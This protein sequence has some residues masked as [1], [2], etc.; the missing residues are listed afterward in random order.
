[1]IFFLC[2]HKAIIHQ[3]LP[4]DVMIEVLN[5]EPLNKHGYTVEADKNGVLSTCTFKDGR[6]FAAEECVA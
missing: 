1:M 6:V 4:Q 5:I 2:H 3:V